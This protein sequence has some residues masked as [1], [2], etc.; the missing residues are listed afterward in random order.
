MRVFFLSKLPCY[1]KANGLPLGAVDG[2]ERT[3]ELDP[4]DGVLLE[5]LCPGR[6]P[7]VCTFGEQLLF[8]PP[9]DIELYFT[10]AGVA[11][12]VTAFRPVDTVMR[13][14]AQ[15]RQGEVLCTLFRQGNVQLS[16]QTADGFA[17]ADLG[18]GFQTGTV[19][20]A[21]ENILVE[22]ANS[23]CILG[24]DGS[25]LT[26]SEGTVSERGPRVTAEIPF[27]DSLGHTA[28]CS[29]EDGKLTACS[30]RTAHEPTPATYALA[31][32]E[33]VLIGGDP[34]PYLCDGLAAKASSL[35]EYLGDFRSVVLGET[36][37]EVGL[38]YQMRPRVFEVRCFRVTADADGKISNI[39]PSS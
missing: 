37:D 7:L 29:Y 13:P 22:D 39:R 6:L 4:A 1:L 32:F 27:H 14:I 36:P 12:Y 19:S 11:L 15:A 38:V 25:I 2:F 8:A 24:R 18:D 16:I 26:R 33:T 28:I 35:G 20:F 31:L 23:F 34:L 5:F 9:E 10:R 21:G 30:I 17:V 3:A